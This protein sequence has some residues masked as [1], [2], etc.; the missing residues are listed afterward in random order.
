MSYITG[1]GLTSQKGHGYDLLAGE[2]IQRTEAALSSGPTDTLT[3][4]RHELSVL[5][6]QGATRGELVR[7][8]VPRK[9][10]D[11]AVG[12]GTQLQAQQA[13]NWWRTWF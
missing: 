9:E 6:T 7:A 8:Q 4:H 5:G 1:A 2:Y 10:K 12:Q 13:G 11:T 3:R